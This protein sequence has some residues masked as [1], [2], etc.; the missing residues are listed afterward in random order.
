VSAPSV[1][2]GIER[3]V[4]DG[5]ALPADEVTTLPAL[6]EAELRRILAGG[7]FPAGGRSELAPVLLSDPPDL[8]SLA[9]VLAERIIADTLAEAWD[10]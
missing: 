9:R 10:G 1:D 5:V 6:V 2:L 8:R 3:I 7:A 4:L